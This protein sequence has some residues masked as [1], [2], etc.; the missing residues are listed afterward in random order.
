ML[1]LIKH[2]AD[3]AVAVGGGGGGVADGGCLVGVAVGGLGVAVSVGGVGLTILLGGLVGSAVGV[4]LCGDELGV[5]PGEGSSICTTRYSRTLLP[6]SSLYHIHGLSQSTTA[7][8]SPAL[9][10][11]TEG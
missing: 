8:T 4:G 1:P 3:V 10:T 9:A 5:L 7:T 2:A 6:S 11:R